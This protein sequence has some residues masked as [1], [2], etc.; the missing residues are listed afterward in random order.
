MAVEI[1][2]GHNGI[3]INQKNI[4]FNNYIFSNLRCNLIIFFNQIPLH[5]ACYGGHSNVIEVLVK[6]PNLKI[7]KNNSS[8]A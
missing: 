5:Y 6:Q 1:L 2:I 4:Y 7:N 8:R 3:N